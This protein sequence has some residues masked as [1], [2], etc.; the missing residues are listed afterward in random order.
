MDNFYFFNGKIETLS[1]F[2]RKLMDCLSEM[3]HRVHMT[4]F[5]NPSE[6]ATLIGEDNNTLITFNCIG[7]SGE[8]EYSPIWKRNN[9]RIINILVDHPMYYHDQ[10]IHYLDYACDNYKII[11]IDA[12]HA[13]YI[14]RYY[15]EIPNV[16]FIPIA[17]AGEDIDVAHIKKEYDVIFT[18][19]FTQCHTFDKYIE[20]NGE[21][22][23]NFYRGM[24][25]DLLCDTSRPI[26]QVCI[27][28]ILRELPDSSPADI[29]L[30]MSNL[31]FVDLYVRFFL[32]EQAIRELAKTG[33]KLRLVGKG[34][35][36]LGLKGTALMP[37][38]FCLEEIAKARISLNVM[39]WFKGGAHDRV[40]SSMICNTLSLTDTSEW[41]ERNFVGGSELIFY[42]NMHMEQLPNIVTDLLNNP[43]KLTE[44]TS[45][46]RKKALENHTWR[47]RALEIIS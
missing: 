29:R 16:A 3:G 40:L 15:P 20:R 1:Y 28:H 41:F 4:E 13:D 8:E 37:T 2:S 11:C 19:N 25:D 33:V 46:G 30:A 42:D 47:S 7:V 38:A 45:M 12:Y 5:Y 27:E 14:R 17:G 36:V 31:M 24:I 35:E 21:E 10:L 22:Y 34:F 39:P 9:F 26:E 6:L 23:A 44:I 18:G 32:R 43:D